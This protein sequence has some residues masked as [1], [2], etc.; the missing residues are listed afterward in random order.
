MAVRAAD[1]ITLAVV[2][3]PSYVRQ[4]YVLQA[5]ALAAPAL[6]T[7]NPPA[8]PW[9]TTEP[10]YTAGSTNTLYTVMLTAYGTVAFEYGPVQQ[11]SSFE[12]AKQAYNLAYSANQAAG[13]ADSKA[14]AVTT[15]TDGWRVSGQTTIDGGKI[16][17]DSVTA[18]ALAADA[19][20]GIVITGS[21]VQTSADSAVSRIVLGASAGVESFAGNS[22]ASY[23]RFN[24]AGLVFKSN[25]GQAANDLTID[26]TGLTFG[27]NAVGNIDGNVNFGGS[28]SGSGIVRILGEGVRLNAGVADFVIPTAYTNVPF[29][30][31]PVKTDGG[32]VTVEAVVM[33]VNGNSGQS[34]RAWLRVTCDG[35][36]V[37]EQL[38]DISIP[39]LNGAAPGVSSTIR[40]RHQPSAGNHTYNVQALCDV[41]SAILVKQAD[42]IISS[43]S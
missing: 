14:T 35:A 18:G 32:K 3:S 43:H 33:I 26:R 11:S 24:S 31:A 15:L 16:A 42:I 30:S 34:R 12:A 10:T 22:A 9:V 19:I 7:A 17:A 1:K 37:G 4:Y 29:L 2:P 36:V 20:D 38:A 39:V 13:A 21:T 27:S 40:V 41:A 5:S 8:A 28:V 23:A 6:P 25:P